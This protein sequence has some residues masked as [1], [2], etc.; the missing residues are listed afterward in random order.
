MIYGIGTD[1]IQID[2]V[3]GV[4]ERTRG[5][6]AEKVLGPRELKVYHARKARSEK[7]GL[8]FLATRFAAKEAFSKAIGL[9]MRWPMTWRAMELLNLQS[10]S[11]PVHCGVGSPDGRF[12]SSMAR[13]VIGQRMPRPMAFE[14]A[15]LAAKRVARKA[16]PRFSERAL[17]AW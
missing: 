5:R 14:N 4:M 6:F 13:H 12:S 9:G 16:S 15:S 8:A 11:S 7:R 2:R 1:I 17:R 3:Q 10:A